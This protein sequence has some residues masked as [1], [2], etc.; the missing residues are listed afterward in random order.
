MS[1]IENGI[2]RAE[3]L[4]SALDPSPAARATQLISELRAHEAEL[5][6]RRDELLS[7]IAPLRA[8]LKQVDGA[9]A[10]MRRGFGSPAKR[11][12]VSAKDPEIK[13]AVLE[14]CASAASLDEI[15]RR[16]STKLGRFVSKKSVWGVLFMSLG[17]RTVARTEVGG[18]SLF[19]RVG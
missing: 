12:L 17:H 8:E 11:P 7:A 5:L 14:A 3:E 18:K 16:V 15:T 13:D 1:E 9:L 4:L 2:L 6:A 19:Q 10:E